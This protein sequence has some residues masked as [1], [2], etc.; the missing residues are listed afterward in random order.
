[1]F[2]KKE[3]K[4]FKEVVTQWLQ[5]DATKEEKL[6]ILDEVQRSLTF[7]L[8]TFTEQVKEIKTSKGSLA[9]VKYIRSQI[10]WD[11]RQAKNFVDSIVL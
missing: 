9:A 7:S 8:T 4:T 10:D 3:M 5:D 2:L 1:M 11:L 6:E